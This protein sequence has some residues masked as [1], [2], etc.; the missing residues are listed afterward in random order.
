MIIT[1][2]GFWKLEEGE[3]EITSNAIMRTLV[4]FWLI[5]KRYSVDDLMRKGLNWYVEPKEETIAPRDLFN[6]VYINQ[7][8]RD[9]HYSPPSRRWK[10]LANGWGERMGVAVGEERTRKG[11]EVL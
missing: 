3:F 5:S 9:G 7:M 2:E 8:V 4:A 11:T 6:Y 10:W 1:K